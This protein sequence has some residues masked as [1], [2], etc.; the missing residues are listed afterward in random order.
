[1]PGF[2]EGVE[3]VLGEVITGIIIAA[4][5][6]GFQTTS[7]EIYPEVAILLVF[8]KIG[9]ILISAEALLDQIED[10]KY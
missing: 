10:I 8:I 2:E 4:A 7:W 9:L 1:M 6:K 3:R 5:L